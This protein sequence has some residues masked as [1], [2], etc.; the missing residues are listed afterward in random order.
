M[1]QSCTPASNAGACEERL[2][3][4]QARD[5][6]RL[7]QGRSM[8]LPSG[9]VASECGLADVHRHVRMLHQFGPRPS[10]R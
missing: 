2:R 7:S 3:S 9:S 4:S 8:L 6:S 5:M 10:Q 1:S